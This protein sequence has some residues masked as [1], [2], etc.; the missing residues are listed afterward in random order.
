MASQEHEKAMDG[1]L[2]RSLARD[3]AS[4]ADCPNA[5]LLAAYY[6][7][8]LG[9][10]EIAEYELHF[11]QC[12]RCRE[13]LAAM[14]RAGAEIES[15]ADRVLEPVLV[16]APAIEARSAAAPVAA[17]AAKPV[18]SPPQTQPQPTRT[19][20]DL[21]WLL[22]VAAAFILTALVYFRLSSQH[23]QVAL[24]HELNV[25]NQPA[26]TQNPPQYDLA[27]QS[28]AEPTA[29][30]PAKKTSRSDSAAPRTAGAPPAA[31]PARP[32]FNGAVS[33]RAGARSTTRG[34]AAA[35]SAPAA[36]R[37]PV[38]ASAEARKSQA[39]AE[40]VL[41]KNEAAAEPAP[42]A[43]APELNPA[44]A[45]SV[46]T[47]NADQSVAAPAP[48]PP[49]EAGHGVG[50]ATS[51]RLQFHGLTAMNS[52]AKAKTVKESAA[53]II[54][55]TSAPNV[56]YRIVP[57]G[58]V[59]LSEDAGASWQRQLLDASAEFAAGSSA[60]PQICWLV[61]RAGVIYRTEDGTSWKKL[62]SPAAADFV[63]VA[64]KDSLSAS[65]TASD[66]RIWS[67][68][69]AGETWNPAK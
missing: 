44:L 12:S 31:T 53:V 18:K 45:D 28:A 68:V 57:G 5:E 50:S 64:A 25:P 48:P 9:A 52:K 27:P 26:P 56:I 19:G 35:N 61:G 63:A 37:P 67:T 2:R 49:A 29:S 36:V 54:V 23:T 62:P 8:S 30:A 13:Q 58:Y 16:S 7:R 10:D 40:Q 66:G 20:L 34:V 51:S 42:A 69:D 4:Q 6:E 22:P 21:R 14:V 47:M 59:E 1:L 38:S 11:S 65:V 39:P 33:A 55:L 15:E 32:Q 24:N 43:P 41:A 3:A 46:T 17:Q 60:T